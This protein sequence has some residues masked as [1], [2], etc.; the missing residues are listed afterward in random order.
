MSQDTRSIE[1]SAACVLYPAEYKVRA[2]SLVAA[3]RLVGGV[4][5]EKA[6]TAPPQTH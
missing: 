1:R 4:D 2:E 3:R 5:I 6:D